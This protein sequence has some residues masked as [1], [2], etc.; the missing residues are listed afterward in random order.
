MRQSNVKNLILTAMFIAMGL[1]LPMAFHAFGLGKA[2]LPMHIPVLL[3]GLI[4]GP[5]YGA[6][7]GFITPLL[8]AL[9]TGMP[10]LFP[11]GVAMMAELCVYGI[12]TG[13][14][15]RGKKWNVYPAL[16]VSML[17]GRVVSGIMNAL[18]LGLA[19]TPFG[20]PIFLTDSFV[21][22]LPGIILQ[23]VVIPVLIMLL[24]RARVIP[25]PRLVIKN[26][27]SNP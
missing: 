8:S 2:F 25:N 22:A 1:L 5:F 16:I 13:F 19:G 26:A 11:T 27:D 9:F 7:C 18:L 21:T 14:L 10:V 12:L 23:I 6:I 17:G 3:C 24:E 15:Y 20:L 4:C